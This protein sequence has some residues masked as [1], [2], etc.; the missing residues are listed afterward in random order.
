MRIIVKATNIN[1]TP[2]INAFVEEKISSIGDII[3]AH[4]NESAIARVEIGKP[5]K[6][7]HSGAVF[8]SEVNFKIGGDLFRAEASHEDLYAAI[9]LTKDEIVRQINKHKTKSVS[10]RRKLRKS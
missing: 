10:A 3:S 7:H 5:S 6:H 1:L 8:R 4:Q 2:A 9:N